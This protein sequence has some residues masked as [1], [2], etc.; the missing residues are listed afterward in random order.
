VVTIS[1]QEVQAIINKAAAEGRNNLLEPEAK[2]IC[3]AYSI[4]TPR[5]EI[6]SSPE[7]AKS[8]AEKL[9]YPVVL[10][11]ISPDIL[12][13]TDVGGVLV[14]L[15]SIEAVEAGYRQ[16]MENARARRPDARIL[17][18]LIQ[19][20]APESTEVIVGSLNDSQFGPTILFGLGGIFVEVLKDVVFRI[21]PLEEHDAREMIT[22][23]RGYPVIMGHRGSPPADQDAIVR[24]I[25]SASRMVTENPQIAQMDLNPVMVYE[26]GASV[27]DAR[28][29]L[30]S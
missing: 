16:I 20:M 3:L 6:A 10:K 27:V 9:G 5:F 1:I 19:K 28:I 4:P 21:A 22:E 24:I 13:K 25:L 26:H 17:G 18:M 7:E 8:Y 29:V 11:I 2:T 15:S 14:G 23:I 30:T 12:H